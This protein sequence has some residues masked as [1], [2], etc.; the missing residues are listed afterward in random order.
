[1]REKICG[2]ETYAQNLYAALCN[3]EFQPQDVWMVLKDDRWSC[4]W[5]HAAS[6]IADIRGDSDYMDW[7]CSGMGFW[8]TNDVAVGYVPEGMVSSEVREDLS[9]L[10]WTVCTPE[11]PE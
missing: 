5:R 8:T 2:S 7:Y 3:N 11:E 9:R 4:T 10:G 6:I 1:M